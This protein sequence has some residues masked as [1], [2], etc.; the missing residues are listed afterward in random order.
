M[1]SPNLEKYYSLKQTQFKAYILARATA[2]TTSCPETPSVQPYLSFSGS[3]KVGERRQTRSTDEKSDSKVWIICQSE[4]RERH[5]RRILERLV[6]KE[7]ETTPSTLLNAAQIRQDEQ[8]LLQINDK[9]L[10]AMDILYHASC[11]AVYVS[12][13]A[14]E[15]KLQT[16]VSS[17]NERHYSESRTRA[18]D[19]LVKHIEKTIVQCPETVTDMTEIC[20][21]YVQFMQQQGVD[22][23]RIFSKHDYLVTLATPCHFTEI[24]SER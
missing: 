6:R 15:Q 13:R 1:R 12:L 9:D 17:E 21:L 2:T 24:G 19:S 3:T 18:F 14:S 22:V 10:W 5:N 7:G 11:Y 4:K 23:E 16:K 8:V 20:A